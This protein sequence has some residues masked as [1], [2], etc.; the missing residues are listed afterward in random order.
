M[1][2]FEELPLA[3]NVNQVYVLT[4]LPVS[5][6]GLQKAFDI[7][8]HMKSTHAPFMLVKDGNMLNLTGGNVWMEMDADVGKSFIEL[9]WWHVHKSITERRLLIEGVLLI[10]VTFDEPINLTFTYLRDQI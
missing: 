5:Q 10:V 7:V 4:V 9:D 3:S 6:K 8:D 2:V 1:N